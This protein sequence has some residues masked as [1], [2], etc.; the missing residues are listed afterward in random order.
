MN[1]K[2]WY[3]LGGLL[4]MV[5]DRITKCIALAVCSGRCTINQFLAFEV[6]YNRGMTWGLLYSHKPIVFMLVSFMIMVITGGVLWYGYDQYK[7]GYSI[8]G[9]TLVVAGSISNIMD[10]FWYGG[11]VDY[12][13]LSYGAWIWPSFNVA[14]MCIVLGILIMLISHTNRGD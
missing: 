4:I 11:V 2:Y 8:I 7:R 9:E 1:R 14:D 6:G 5:A 10:R 12:I 13:E 3:A